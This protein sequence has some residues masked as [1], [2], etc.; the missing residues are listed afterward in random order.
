MFGII[1]FYT[2]RFWVTACVVFLCASVIYSQK[3]F[4]QTYTNEK[5]LNTQFIND[6]TQ[7]LSG[8]IW[9]ATDK[10]VS[11]YDGYSW[12]SYEFV[13]KQ[14]VSRIFRVFCDPSGIVYAVPFDENTPISIISGSVIDT[15]SRMP[16]PNGLGARDYCYLA[17]K[18]RQIIGIINRSI[19][20]IYKNGSWSIQQPVA[21]GIRLTYL[22]SC[23]TIGDKCYITGDNGII[24]YDGELFTLLN[25]LYPGI[26]RQPVHA[27]TSYVAGK[28][29]IL[30][31]LF[32]SAI[33]KIE[34]GKYSLVTGITPLYSTAG[35]DYYF[36]GCRYPFIIYGSVREKRAYHLEH[37]TT[38]PMLVDNGFSALGGNRIFIDK[39]QNIWFGGTRGLDRLSN[40]NLTRYDKETGMLL[41][42]VS[43]VTRLNPTTLLVGHNYGFSFIRGN[44]ITVKDYLARYPFSRYSGRILQIYKENAENFWIAAGNIGLFHMN[45]SG[46]IRQYLTG[47]SVSYNSL[48]VLPDGRIFTASPQ[49][50]LLWQKNGEKGLTLNKRVYKAEFRKLYY[51][52]GR[53]IYLSGLY[54]FGRI[55]LTTNVFNWM[56]TGGNQD[57]NITCLYPTKHDSVLV[58]AQQGLFVYHNGTYSKALLSGKEIDN[59]VYTIDYDVYGNLWL[60][61]NNGVIRWDP[62]RGLKHISTFDGLAGKEV[63]RG[64]VFFDDAHHLWLGTDK[65][66]NCIN[67]YNQDFIVPIPSRVMINL[68]VGNEQFD[69]NSASV[70]LSAD[71]N[72]LQFHIRALSFYNEDYLE[73]QVRLIGADTVWRTIKQSEVNLIRY[74]NLPPGNYCMHVRVR[75]GNGE[76]SKIFTSTLITIKPT[77]FHT[78]WFFILLIMAISG[79]AYLG[80]ELLFLRKHR[81]ILRQEVN[82]QTQQLLQSEEK[83]RK[84][85]DELEMLVQERTRELETANATLKEDLAERANMQRAI[86]ELGQ[87]YQSI[88]MTAA[89]PMLLVDIASGLI[90][91]ANVSAER[92]YG[93]DHFEFRELTFEVL[94]SDAAIC[95]NALQLMER[96]IPYT[97]HVRKD[98]SI[99]PV[100]VFADYF[101]QESTTVGVINI[102]DISRF[103]DTE[104]RLHEYNRALEELNV[105]KDKFFSIIAHDLKSPFH[106]LLGLSE[107]LVTDYDV[108]EKEMIVN[109][110]NR[111]H[112]LSRRLFSLVE[113][114]L[115]WSRLQTGRIDMTLENISAVSVAEAAKGV[116]TENASVKHIAIVNGVQQGH[117]VVANAQMV[118]QIFQNLMGNAIKFSRIGSEVRVESQRLDN[119]FIAFRVIDHGVGIA[120][121]DIDKVFRI[122]IHFTSRGTNNEEG[123]GLGLKLCKEMIEKQGGSI[124]VHSVPEEE[125]VFTFTLP[126]ADIPELN[127]GA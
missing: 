112:N 46:T 73:Y 18:S 44:T 80:F 24:V 78:T 107:I 114:L 97:D 37:T 88:F 84:I 83:L 65:A 103:I 111:I 67:D 108:L 28:D 35:Y 115:S 125:T 69:L 14:G 81:K 42:E 95:T 99:I 91:E 76:W 93:Y 71:K 4:V 15:I 5:G 13:Y 16:A 1:G 124:S 26:T 122:D 47:D 90:L 126:A 61:T 19:L 55:D 62:K 100:E 30:Y 33:G 110:H 36:I 60:G 38:Q 52:G 48:V 89:D 17:G 119:G 104:N 96:H 21:N 94:F 6:V 121:A 109:L 25:K 56:I 117:V 57:Y 2:M 101:N 29:T 9:V 39:E 66:L 8:R 63:N 34:N 118:F 12:R 92:V 23:T 64:A 54:G 49:G 120:P 113:S 45:S 22:S 41:S 72:Y 3:F 27:I 59:S 85:N 10:G 20:K 98:G 58:G 77:F 74:D 127:T 123:S 53:F 31:L 51:P 106:G 7:D 87:K 40:P 68:V 102:R 86:L 79:M 32:K 50:L 11:V 70:P 75:N 105:S 116:L 82:R 43:A